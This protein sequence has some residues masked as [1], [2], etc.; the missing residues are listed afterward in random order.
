MFNCRQLDYIRVLTIDYS[1]DCDTTTHRLF[2]SLAGALI[3]SVSLGVPLGMLAL[4][5]K[6]MREYGNADDSDRFVARRVA[7]ELKLPDNVASD[8][9]FGQNHHWPIHRLAL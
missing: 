8:G 7:D 5:V 1:V 2:Q 4:M 9:T 6:R 3:I